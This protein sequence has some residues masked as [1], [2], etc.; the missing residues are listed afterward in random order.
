M[1][2]MVSPSWLDILLTTLIQPTPAE[3]GP[4]RYVSI[5][6]KLLVSQDTEETMKSC[7]L[8]NLLRRLLIVISPSVFLVS[9]GPVPAAEV[10]YDTSGK[11][12]VLCTELILME[13]R[14]MSQLC[15]WERT[16]ADDAID[17][18]INDIDAFVLEN[19]STPV[20]QEQLDQQKLDY[21]SHRE[22]PGDT[23]PIRCVADPVKFDTDMKFLWDIH[24]QDPAKLTAWILDLLSIPR[25]PLLNPCL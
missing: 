20:T 24:Q 11:G 3:E 17:R 22:K 6:R 14:Y 5:Q 18:A 8:L 12:A 10:Q 25:E 2:R 4:A 21:F 23:S 1:T 15:K 16:P 7:T 19:S 9:V 13:V